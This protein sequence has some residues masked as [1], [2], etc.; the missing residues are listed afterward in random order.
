MLESDVKITPV[1][2]ATSSL[3]KLHGD[4]LSTKGQ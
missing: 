3:N 2:S 4:A 1:G